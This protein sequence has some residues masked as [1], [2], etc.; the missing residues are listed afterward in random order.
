[1]QRA[2]NR[3]GEC[4]ACRHDGLVNVE[5]INIGPGEALKPA[6]SVAAVAGKGLRGDRHFAADDA[7]PGQ[8]SLGCTSAG[9]RTAS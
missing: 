7:K 8:A 1:M 5:E 6:A 4:G 9:S 2:G 3:V